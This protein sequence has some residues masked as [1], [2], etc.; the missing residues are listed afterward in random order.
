MDWHF[1]GS[2]PVYQQIMA[3]VRQRILT[4]VYQPGSRVPSV[5]D[6]ATET[7]VNPNTVQR[8]LS[9]L[10]LEGLLV[11]Y[12]TL[13]RCV[14]QDSAVLDRLRQQAIDEAVRTCAQRFKAAG[15]T[16]EQAANLLLSYDETKD[17]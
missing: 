6:L 9:E 10:E 11:N 4:E 1:T 16:M 13:G 17:V 7:R 8:A 15:L 12:G 3:Q 5:R 2:E 14:T